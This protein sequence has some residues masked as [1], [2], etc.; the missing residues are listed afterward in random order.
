MNVQ[1]LSTAF[2]DIAV[3]QLFYEQQQKGLGV[4]FQDAIFA[5]IDSLMVYAGIHA[6]VFGFYRTLSKTFPYAIYY[7]ME[8][9]GVVVWRVLDC[10]AKPSRTK[11]VLKN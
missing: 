5:D 11:K 1:V 3:A 8:A 2:S 7:K 6:Q 10:R 9:E 4:Y